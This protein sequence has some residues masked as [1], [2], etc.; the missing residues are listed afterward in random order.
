MEVDE[1]RK[2]VILVALIV[3][4][5]MVSGVSAVVLETN[6]PA[7]TT[8]EISGKV[9]DISF[10]FEPYSTTSVYLIVFNDEEWVTLSSSTVPYGISAV[11]NWDDIQYIRK[12]HVYTLHFSN[13]K[14]IAGTRWE[15]VQ[16]D[17]IVGAG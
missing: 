8:R 7:G 1:M 14:V 4:C 12:N 6:A 3:I 15:L 17:E 2:I 16:I 9:T 5:A 13:N 11:A 10:D